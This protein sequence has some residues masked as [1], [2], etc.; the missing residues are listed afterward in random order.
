MTG[1]TTLPTAARKSKLKKYPLIYNPI[2]EYWQ[3]I[4]SGQ[5]V[6]SAKIRKTYRHVV[7]QMDNPGEYFYSPARAN[8]VLEFFENYCHHSKGS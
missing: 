6:V 3:A 1:S 2:R 7:D 8:H 4:E 5:E